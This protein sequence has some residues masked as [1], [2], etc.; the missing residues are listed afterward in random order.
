MYGFSAEAGDDGRLRHGKRLSLTAAKL[1]RRCGGRGERPEN[2]RVFAAREALRVFFFQ[3][4]DD[5]FAP[6]G[7]RQ[8]LNDRRCDAVQSGAH[9]RAPFAA[10]AARM[11]EM[12][13]SAS[14]SA[15]EPA[16]ETVKQRGGT[17]H[18][19]PMEVPGGDRII[20]ISD[21]E[22]VE[23]GVVGPGE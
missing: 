19:G 15:R 2:A 20:V 14:A 1:K 23:V 10:W 6:V 11:R 7:W 22:G 4:A 9:D 12:A 3:I 17:V 18:R 5:R 13:R 8:A 16:A 21:P